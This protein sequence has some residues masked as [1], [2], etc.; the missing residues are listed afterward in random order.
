M[1]IIGIN[2]GGEFFDENAVSVKTLTDNMRRDHVLK[3]YDLQKYYD[4]IEKLYKAIFS[5]DPGKSKSPSFQ[6]GTLFHRSPM[7]DIKTGE[8]YY[9]KLRSI[10]KNGLLPVDMLVSSPDATDPTYVSF[11]SVLEREKTLA[12]IFKRSPQGSVDLIFFV[13]TGAPAIAQLMRLGRCYGDNYN[14]PHFK[15]VL[16]SGKDEEILKK[17]FQI[18]NAFCPDNIDVEGVC[19]LPI[20]VPSKYISAVVVP[21]SLKSDEKLLGIIA[22]GFPEAAILGGD[23]KAVSPSQPE[24]MGY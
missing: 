23:G 17:I 18:Q 4:E 10:A 7:R 24:P 21:E 19:Y 20:G 5:S 9:D 2:T 8:V 22:E 11:H 16:A 15:D 6:A 12:D 14:P 3:Q 1:E 13:N